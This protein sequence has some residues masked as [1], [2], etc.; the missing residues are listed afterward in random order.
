VDSTVKAPA[1][2][3]RLC[4]WLCAK[5]GF[6]WGA[7]ILNIALATFSAWLFTPWSTDFKQL[8]IGLPLQNPLVTCF[9]FI[10]VLL[11]T[12]TICA[13]SRMPVA[14][15]DRELRRRY[16]QRMLAETHMQVVE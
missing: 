8:P 3:I 11:L 16:L 6:I 15:S 10:I 4:A 13:V 1:W 12:A 14:P 7:V 2:L 9:V 5:Q